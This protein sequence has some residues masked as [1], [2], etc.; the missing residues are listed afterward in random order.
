MSM[1]II[2]RMSAMALPLTKRIHSKSVCHCNKNPR[3][4]Q[5]HLDGVMLLVAWYVGLLRAF[6]GRLSELD[7][8]RSHRVFSRTPAPSLAVK[9]LERLLL[10]IFG[11]CCPFLRKKHRFSLETLARMDG[12]FSFFHGKKSKVMSKR[13]WG[14][15]Y[16]KISPPKIAFCI[17]KIHSN[18]LHFFV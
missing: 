16:E 13:H 12:W 2:Q 9:W 18:R 10:F 11:C 1:T 6:W 17:Y 5:E 3:R 7:N 14:P 15:G 4:Q 8:C